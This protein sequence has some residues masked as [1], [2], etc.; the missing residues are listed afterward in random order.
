M[1]HHATLYI[2][3]LKTVL[4]QL[5]EY[6]HIPSADIH[7][8]CCDRLSI[9]EVRT[10]VATAA[11]RPVEHEK[12]RFLLSF[13]DAP[14]EAQNALLKTLE[15]PTDTAEFYV[16]VPRRDV[17]MPTV[18][19]RLLEVELEKEQVSSD[20]AKTFFAQT[21]KEQSAE[22]ASKAKE[23]D[24]S[25]IDVFLQSVEQLASETK[26][27]SL[28]QAVILVRTYITLPGASRK[29]LLEYI[30]LSV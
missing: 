27:V 19:S 25:W 22:I 26:N 4:P 24:A 10:L 9:D 15:E 28:L 29:M 18:L 13:F 16:V 8:I 21:Y 1:Q 17:L 5:P 3:S 23:N 20:M 14:H 11:Q 6:M 7:H 12:R 30:Q 2:G